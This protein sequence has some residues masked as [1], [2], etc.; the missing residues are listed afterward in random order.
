M[1]RN[2][3]DPAGDPGRPIRSAGAGYLR[4]RLPH[5]RRH[6]YTRL[7]PCDRPGPRAFARAG[8]SRGRW[9]Q[10][11]AESWNWAGPFVLAGCRCHRAVE[12]APRPR[13][14]A[15]RRLGDPAALVAAPDRAMHL[16]NWQPVHSDLGQIVET[17]WTAPRISWNIGWYQVVVSVA[18][19]NIHWPRVTFQKF[20]RYFSSLFS[21]LIY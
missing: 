12:W 13:A 6:C 11:C 18:L 10:H 3:S 2:P 8:L 4:D 15:P 5:P 19:N 7:H 21:R 16:L 9:R 20:S 17:A 14:E 1:I